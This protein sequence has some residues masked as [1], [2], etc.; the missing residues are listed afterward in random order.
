MTKHYSPTR[1]AQYRESDR[2]R[3]ERTMQRRSERTLK[4]ATRT[5]PSNNN[6]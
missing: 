3:R 6:R 4:H 2:A 1:A 5:A